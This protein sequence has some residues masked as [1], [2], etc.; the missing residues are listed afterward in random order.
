MEANICLREE[1]LENTQAFIWTLKSHN[2]GT[3]TEQ[4]LGQPSP[5]L[6]PKLESS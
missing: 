3:R 2:L 1:V 5:G 4:I 6:K